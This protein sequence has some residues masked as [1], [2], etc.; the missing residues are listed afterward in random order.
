MAGRPPRAAATATLP[1]TSRRTLS[2]HKDPTWRNASPQGRRWRGCGGGGPGR[3][4]LTGGGAAGTGRSLRPSI[5]NRGEK[6][7]NNNE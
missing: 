6:G 4:G 5:G 3:A 7:H 1:A 2:S